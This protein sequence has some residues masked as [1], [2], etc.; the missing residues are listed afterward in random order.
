MLKFENCSIGHEQRLYEILSL[1]LKQG[2]FVALIGAN[3]SG[4]STLMDS[5]VQGKFSNGKVSFEGQDWNDLKLLA[6]ARKI[7][8]V[9]N[10]FLGFDYLKVSEYLELGRH[11][12]TGFT[13]RLSQEDKSII[14]KYIQTL[15]LDS[16]LDQSTSTLSD[17]ERQ[18]VGIAKALI[19]ETPIVL[20]DEP[21]AFLDYPTKREVMSLLGSIA[22]ES[23][24]LVIIA[25]HDIDFCIEFCSRILVIEKN[26]KTLQSHQSINHDE[27]VKQAFG[28]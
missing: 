6:R 14:Q 15:H 25:S 9:D 18:R 4:K 5:L 28:I 1:E 12:Y 24:R 27:L 2:E 23:K 13:G 8:L 17:G 20:L 21:T 7:T 16:L 3:G 26:S 19:Q 22:K 10:H 11:S